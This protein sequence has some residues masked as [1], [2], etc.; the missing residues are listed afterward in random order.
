MANLEQAAIF[1]SASFPSGERGQKF[2]PYDASAVVDAVS[3]FC[4]AVLGN[5]GRLVFGGHPTITPL[6]LTI[7]SELQVENSVLVF[8]SKW[9]EDQKLSYRDEIVRKKLGRIVWTPKATGLNESL[10]TMRKEM[11]DS[12]QYR[13][14]IFIGGMERV[15][16]EYLMMTE[17]WPSTPCVPVA[18]PGGAAAQLPTA[19]CEHLGIG[20]WVKSRAYPFLAH[21]V[22]NTLVANGERLTERSA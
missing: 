2:K 10:Q 14:A 22:V 18:G 7:S 3:A 20:R 5:N 16:E 21:Q 4:R 15:K 9:F 12:I 13:G 1:L 8:Q 11:I 19:D 6:V 17:R